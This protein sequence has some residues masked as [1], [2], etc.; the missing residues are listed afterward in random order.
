MFS[1]NYYLALAKQNSALP[2]KKNSSVKNNIFENEIFVMQ[3]GS[4]SFNLKT[5]MS[6]PKINIVDLFLAS[7]DYVDDKI[8]LTVKK[9]F[10]R[11]A[12]NSGHFEILVK[13]VGAGVYSSVYLND[14]SFLLLDDQISYQQKNLD[15]QR[16]FKVFHNQAYF[17]REALLVG[18]I[19]HLAAK[20]ESIK[21]KIIS[22]KYFP[23][24]T[25]EQILT[26]YEKQKKLLDQDQQQTL[27]HNIFTAWYQ[28]VYQCDI[29]HRDLSPRN[30]IVADNF[31]CKIIDFGNAKFFNEKI[32]MNGIT[33][34]YA[35]PEMFDSI[36]DDKKDTT[37]VA[38]DIRSMAH[39]FGR[40]FGHQLQAP[41]YHEEWQALITKFQFNSLTHKMPEP[42]ANFL[43]EMLQ[44]ESGEIDYFYNSAETIFQTQDAE[45]QQRS[46]SIVT[47]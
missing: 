8:T 16:V 15:H 45:K 43:N 2:P 37:T 6:A 44:A 41:T 29:V 28:Q 42:I 23:G 5:A 20:I 46:F 10:Y 14:A 34:E 24:K 35:A 9:S 31:E 1:G 27:C 47:S 33:Y 21:T 40:I 17:K 18:S 7:H 11:A 26:D 32:K 3:V 25:L 13:E 39:I 38:T 22:F 4:G 19:S 36:D 30:I 12:G